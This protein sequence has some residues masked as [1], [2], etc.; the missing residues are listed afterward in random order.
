MMAP[1]FGFR[2]TLM[3]ALEQIALAAVLFLL[4]AGWLRIPDAHAFELLCSAV[5]AL[6][7]VVLMGV[8]ESLIALRLAGRPANARQLLLGCCA[9]LVAA[10]LC[11]G[12]SL[13]FE[14]LS[15]NDGLRAG[16]VNSRLPPKMR[17]FFSYEHLLTCFGWI[18]SGLRW[19]VVCLLAAAAFAFVTSPRPLWSF[20][21]MLRTRRYWLCLLLLVVAG[22]GVSGALLAWTPGHNLRIQVVSLLLRLPIAIGVDAVAVALLLQAMAG[23]VSSDQST[24]S[25]EPV[26][27]QPRTLGIP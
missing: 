14:R 7:I 8:G 16:Y 24:G 22:A 11:Y 2:R 18:W 9:V 1:R 19:I 10:I 12:A 21:A 17:M 27:S 23:A 26:S 13:C 20:A 25:E 5:L 4:I 6:L 15:I 3:L